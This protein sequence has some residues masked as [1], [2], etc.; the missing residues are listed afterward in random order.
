[1]LL[2]GTTFKRVEGSKNIPGGEAEQIE[3]REGKSLQNAPELPVWQ[4]KMGTGP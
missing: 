4:L 1:M 2:V 3:A